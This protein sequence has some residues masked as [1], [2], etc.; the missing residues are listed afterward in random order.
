VDTPP[1]TLKDTKGGI[2]GVFVGES[3]DVRTLPT[4][5]PEK[6]LPVVRQQKASRQA[7]KALEKGGVYFEG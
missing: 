7:D 6:A 5:P 4:G 2:V 1:S 3:F